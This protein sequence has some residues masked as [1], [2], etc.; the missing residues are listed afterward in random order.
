[1][2]SYGQNQ[3]NFLHFLGHHRQR[4]IGFS[5]LALGIRRVRRVANP[6]EI[7]KTHSKKYWKRVTS[8]GSS[9]T[10]KS[11]DKRKK[12]QAGTRNHHQKSNQKQWE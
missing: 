1:M 12:P 2:D 7:C 6:S 10:D 9:I 5:S 3:A 8:S 4:G 11:C